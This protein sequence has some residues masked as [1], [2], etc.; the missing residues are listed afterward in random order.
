[1]RFDADCSYSRFANRLFQRLV[2]KKKRFEAVDF[3]YSIFETCYLRDCVFDSCDFT[4]CRFIGTNLAG[5]QFCGCTFNY[6][7]FERTIIDSD[8]LDTE[9][10]R[11]ENV[12]LRF[13]RSLRVNY[14]QLGDADSAHRALSIELRATAEHWLKAWTHAEPYHEGKY[15][16]KKRL[17]ALYQWFRVWSWDLLWGSGES[18]LKLFRSFCVFLV[19]ITLVHAGTSSSPHRIDTFIYALSEAPQIFFGTLTPAS[20]P[21]WILTGIVLVRFLTVGLFTSI[22]VK[23]LSRR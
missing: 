4:G 9:C 23:R 16:G 20:I 2:A 15:R 12:R 11:H 13:A 14:Q 21:R 1:M 8:L 5:S 6:A 7:T 10:P 3:K 17:R 19:V 22:V 18:P